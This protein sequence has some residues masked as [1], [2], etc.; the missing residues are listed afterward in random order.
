MGG[1]RLDLT[2]KRFGRLTV[3][4]KAVG[5]GWHC[6]CSCGQRIVLGQ[7]YLTSGNTQSCGCQKIDSAIKNCKSRTIHGD[8]R[9]GKM[10]PEYRS[11]SQMIQRCCNSNNPAYPEYGGRGIKVCKRWMKYENFLSDMGRKPTRKHSLDRIDND[12]DY[13]PSNC[14]WTTRK[15]QAGNRRTPRRAHLRGR[16]YKMRS[17]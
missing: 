17:N 16:K 14:R 2:G 4:K 11:W 6:R 15:Q 13:R 5:P 1:V 10:K 7:W 9:R 12:G 3:V 8:N